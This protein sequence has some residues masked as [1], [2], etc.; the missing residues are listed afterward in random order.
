M[1]YSLYLYI[2][3]ILFGLG[4]LYRILAWFRGKIGKDSRNISLT[5][6]ILSA[7]KGTISV[8]F[9]VKLFILIKAFVLD[10]LLQRRILRENLLRW[11]M[12][13]FIYGGFVLLLLMHALGRILTENIFADYYSTINPF[14][15]L[16]DFFGLMVIV[17]IIIAVYRR[18]ILKVPRLSTNGM[19]IYLIVMVTIIIL[20]G[21]V[22]EGMKITSYTRYVEMIEEF[23]DIDEDDDLKALE[24]YWVKEFSVESPNEVSLDPEVLKYGTVVHTDNCAMCH[25]KPV[26]AFTGYAT[27]KIIKPLARQ[28]D[29]AGAA[30]FL[31]YF[32]VIVCL[33]AMAYLP[34]SKMFHILVTPLSLM[35]NAVMDE[36]KSDPANIATKQV[37]ELDACV[38]CGT[39]SLRCSALAANMVAGNPDILPSEKMQHIKSMVNGKK[40][41]Q[42]ELKLLQEGVYLCTNCDRCTVVCP[43][44][45]N[46][47]DL[48]F[49]VREDLIGNGYALPFVLSQLSYYR[50]LKNAESK[51]EDYSKPIDNARGTFTEKLDKI[52]SN[53]SVSM[54][55]IDT[56][57][58]NEL[59]LSIDADTFSNCFACSTCSTSC[60]VVNNYENPVEVLGLL[61][62]Q[63]IHTTVLGIKDMAHGSRMLW[64]C[65]TCY[66]CQQSCPQEVKITEV[67]YKLKNRAVDNLKVKEE[68]LSETG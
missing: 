47:R 53:G 43:S 14:M 36:N 17:G 62:H 59:G 37:M 56:E 11:L 54:D 6:R 39:C 23:S 44:G 57:Y 60:P 46:L 29:E 12:H 49:N 18:F 1:D 68:G 58:L 52:K 42:D 7:V 40:L 22:L 4:M 45:I 67:F 5:Q 33:L 9:S 27:G 10:A 31:F 13:M 24:A 2:S 32:H 35:A 48:W 66:K 21:I 26:W 30:K 16:R 64:D 63:I 50:G 34:F 8:I 25:S 55:E 3:L 19:D 38:H 65:L 41:K 20:S 61:P 15:F 28:L 51:S